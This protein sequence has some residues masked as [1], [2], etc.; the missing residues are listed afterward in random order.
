MIFPNLATDQK[1]TVTSATAQGSTRYPTT[2]PRKTAEWLRLTLGTALGRVADAGG[3]V[4]PVVQER[5]AFLL[6]EVNAFVD[7]SFDN[8]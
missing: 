6:L 8:I 7:L 2:R 1:A 5:D 4:P 3:L